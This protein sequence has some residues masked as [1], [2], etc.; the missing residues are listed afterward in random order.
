M[1]HPVDRLTLQRAILSLSLPAFLAA[2]STASKD[3]T[4]AYVSP[5]QYQSYDCQQ[6]TAESQRIQ[7]RYLELGGRLDQAASNDKTLVGVGMILFWPALFALGGTKQQE[8]EYARLKGEHDAVQQTSVQ[9]R[10]GMGAQQAAA[11]VQPAASAA[12]N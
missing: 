1:P 11:A 12:A 3:I 10:C 7:S 2:C 8:A 4:A 5:M 9:K 6:L